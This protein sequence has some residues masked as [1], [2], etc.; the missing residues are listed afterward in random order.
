[1]AK[2]AETT[3]ADVSSS[4][5]RF[6]RPT[7]TSVVSNMDSGDEA[8]FDDVY[9]CTR[10]VVERWRTPLFPGHPS[11]YTFTQTNKHSDSQRVH[12]AGHPSV[13]ICLL[14]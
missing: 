6:P 11:D 10:V 14:I 9:E 13:C 8:Q 4:P 12:R 7:D 2:P 5:D 1:M 3:V